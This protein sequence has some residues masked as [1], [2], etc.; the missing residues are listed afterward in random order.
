[1]E[2]ENNGYNIA[3]FDHFESETLVE[4]KRVKYK[5]LEEMVYKMELTYDDIVGILDVKYIA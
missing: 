1:M 3:G 5:G 4:L 2:M